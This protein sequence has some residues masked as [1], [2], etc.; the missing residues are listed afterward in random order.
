MFRILNATQVYALHLV[1]C[2]W[3]Q[4]NPTWKLHNI[5]GIMQTT[6][7]NGTVRWV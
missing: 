1:A 2:T 5:H 7:A 4:A 6:H 3:C